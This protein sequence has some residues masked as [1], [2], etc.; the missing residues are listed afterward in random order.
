LNPKS[1][2]IELAGKT[3]IIETGKLAGQ[4]NGA[5]TVQCGDTIVLVT[6]VGSKEPLEG[7]DFFPL[8]VDVEE[9]MY[10]AGKIPGGF[11]KREGRP[12]EKSIL[13]ARLVDRPIR[14]SF[15]K[16]FRNEIQIIATILSVDQIN[17]PDVLA[18]IGA[19][20]ALTISD[21]PF[22]NPVGGVRVG[23][24]G[25]RWIINPT[26]QELE[27][28]DLD[29]IVAGNKNAIL[30]VEAGAREVSED[31]VL[32]AL[33]EAHEAIKKIIENLERFCEI[34][35][36]PKRGLVLAETDETIKK[37][38][39][40]L[41][42]K[43]MREVLKV[44]D[45]QSRED[46]VTKL[47]EQV[48]GEVL[49]KLPDASEKE[50]DIDEAFSQL[51]REE[52]RRMI[53]EDNIRVDGRGLD[54]IRPISCEVAVLPRTHGTGLFTRG[55]TQ[56][57]SVLTLGTVSEEQRVDGVGIEE[58]KRFMHHYNFPPFCTGDIG[59]MR[60][61]RR[62]EIGHGAL[63]ERALT[64]VIPQESEFPYTVRLVSEVLESNGSSSM[65]SVCGS[66]LALMDAGVPIKAPVAGIAMG[67]VKENDK[68]TILTD[69]LG[70]ED[71]LGDMDFK[72]A[73][74][75]DGI[76]ALQMDM[77]VEGVGSEILKEALEEAKK[78]RLFILQ[79]IKEVIPEPRLE[80]SEFAPR[81]IS[82]KI[83][84]DKIREVIGP[85]GKTIRGIID[86]T[87]TTIDIEDDGTVFI[88]SKDGVSGERAREIIEMIT[89]EVKRGDQYLGTVTKT[90]NFGAFVEI[91]PGKEGLVH[92][93]RLAR[94]RIA[95]VEDVVKVGDKI[96][97]EVID[98][99][100]QNRI[101]LTAV[102]AG[103]SKP[104]QVSN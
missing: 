87:G 5:V 29:V 57:L 33:Q 101:S 69:I 72:V 64:P 44:H 32:E 80:L 83:D 91:L 17:P 84:Q 12:S 81:V 47:K 61:P 56:V 54:E 74:T 79:K 30:M 70:M 27:H 38:V 58:S 16:G 35:G 82:L 43:K 22:E 94:Q 73:G 59:M 90:T 85:G 40:K 92:I 88:A 25:N 11:I 66:T 24:A 46:E 67:L 71:A 31:I 19:S 36:V 28:G 13:N 102:D 41:A 98:I 49:S 52:T 60:G 89:K 103:L 86:E 97:V 6:V 20:A 21:I 50:R 48:K 53:L 7:V 62:R 65:A 10:A 99:D 63:V 26:F 77:K 23:H 37:E 14:P 9:K 4:A 96:L 95:R 68:V 104:R 3:I 55:Q 100:R 15:P 2:E 76:T 1:I 75:E 8:V 18:L 45:K 34:A 78:A 51:E 42:L 93:S 39:K